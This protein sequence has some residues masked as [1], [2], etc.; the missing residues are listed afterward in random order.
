MPR[1][2]TKYNKIVF[3][4]QSLRLYSAKAILIGKYW[5]LLVIS[6]E[7]LRKMWAYIYIYTVVYISCSARTGQIAGLS[8][9]A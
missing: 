1:L 5:S 2:S 4:P 8:K 6:Y 3:L 7:P 9:E